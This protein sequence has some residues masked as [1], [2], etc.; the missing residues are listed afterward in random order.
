MGNEHKTVISAVIP[1]AGQGSRMKAGINKQYLTLRGKPILAYTL[2]IFEDS[3]MIDE[4]ILVVNQNEFDLCR[5]QVLSKRKYR[6]VKLAAGG[7]TRQA[8]VHR[9]LKAVRSDCDLVM[10]HDGARPLLS[11]DVLKRCILETEKCGATVTAV[12]AKN[13]I[14]VVDETGLV[15]RTP[16]R[17]TLYEVNTPQSFRYDL[18][19]KVYQMA[20]VEGVQG[21]DDASLVEHYGHAVK[22]VPDHYKNIKITTPEDL[23]IAESIIS[24]SR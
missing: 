17:K 8:S 1:A 15:V 7:D 10:I 2:D 22:V 19:M 21:T 5:K 3:P 23:I 11:K 24:F 16:E 6:K 18:I 20:A 12:P 4:I 14:K 9:G 13:T